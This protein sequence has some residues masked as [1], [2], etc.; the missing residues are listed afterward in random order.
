MLINHGRF[1]KIMDSPVFALLTG[2]LFFGNLTIF[3]RVV[4]IILAII[5]KKSF[6][7]VLLAFFFSYIYILWIILD[8]I[9]ELIKAII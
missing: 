6:W 3:I 7:G 8:K 2:E 1:N 5:L 9:I 4:A